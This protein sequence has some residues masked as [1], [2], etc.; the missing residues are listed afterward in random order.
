MSDMVDPGIYEDEEN[1]CYMMVLH[2]HVYCRISLV[3]NI[4]ISIENMLNVK[5]Q[6]T[7][8]QQ[9]KKIARTV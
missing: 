8:P 5:Q 1:S 7:S 2:V 3:R 4:A 6:V 9:L